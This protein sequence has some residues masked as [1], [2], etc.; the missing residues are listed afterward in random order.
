MDLKVHVH[1]G[2][3]LKTGLWILWGSRQCDRQVVW[4]IR[5]LLE[6]KSW[7]SDWF[8]W[9]RRRT[10]ENCRSEGNLLERRGHEREKKKPSVR[11]RA[12]SQ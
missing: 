2:G 11:I 10:W 9:I 4:L 6:L 7:I 8:Y 12:Y 5:S 1:Y 3:N